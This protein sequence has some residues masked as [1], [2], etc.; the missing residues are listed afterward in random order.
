MGLWC[1]Y[2]LNEMGELGNKEMMDIVATESE[3]ARE[4]DRETSPFSPADWP[5]CFA[6][7]P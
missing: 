2:Q 1:V 5:K 6:A 4:R 3:R 7:I